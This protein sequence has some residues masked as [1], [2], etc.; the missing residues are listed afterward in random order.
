MKTKTKIFIEN[1]KVG[2]YCWNCEKDTMVTFKY[3]AYKTEDGEKIENVLQGF[4][5][6]CKE[7]LLLPPQSTPRIKSY[8]SKQSKTQEYMVPK[9]IE[10]V[11]LLV[12]EH[13]GLEKPDVFKVMLRFYLGNQKKDSW[14]KLLELGNI[15]KPDTRLSFRVD[16]Q[17]DE[18]LMAW[19][20][21]LGI[22]KNMLV[23]KMIWDAKDRLID[24]GI[25]SKKFLQQTSLL[26]NRFVS[27][28]RH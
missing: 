12:G 28:F 17:T 19:C 15:G 20:T 4:C 3:K 2:A 9:A 22:S 13:A 7:R 21:K 23:T 8:N 27:G 6:S 5:D 10:D 18:T 1:E 14:M 25:I 24:G 16:P 11:L 26:S